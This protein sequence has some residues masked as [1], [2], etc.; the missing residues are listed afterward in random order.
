[1]MAFPFTHARRALGGLMSQPVLKPVYTQLRRRGY[2]K[3]QP[4]VALNDFADSLAGAVAELRE[5][6][7]GT[8]GDYLEF[9]VSRGTSMVGAYR[10]FRKMGLRDTRLFGF[11]SFQGMPAGSEREGWVAGQYASSLRATRHY[12][13]AHLVDPD[14]VTLVEGWFDDTLSDETRADLGINRASILMIDCDI[15]SASR[16]ALEFCAPVLADR[17]VIIFDDWGPMERL[18]K[19][20]QKEAFAEFLEAHPRLQARPLPAYAYQGQDNARVFLVERVKA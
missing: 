7:D 17:A 9:G 6:D 20:G 19:I 11:D 10:V 4:L 14:R 15:Y 12:L 18:G 3:W 8:I 16:Q 5:G 1:M 2:T 13:D